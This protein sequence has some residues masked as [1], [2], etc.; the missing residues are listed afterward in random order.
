[1]VT[2]RS[3]KLLPIFVT[4]TLKNQSPLEFHKIGCA[5]KIKNTV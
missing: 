5:K 4:V 2:K 3:N 1:M